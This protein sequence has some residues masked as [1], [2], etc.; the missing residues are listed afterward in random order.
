MMISGFSHTVKEVEDGTL[1]ILR[2]IYYQIRQKNAKVLVNSQ[3]SSTTKVS[4]ITTTTQ[5]YV[6]QETNE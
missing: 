3:W 5:Q 1:I 6:E 4:P 2:D